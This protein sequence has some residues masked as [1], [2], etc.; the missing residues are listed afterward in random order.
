MVPGCLLL[1]LT[2]GCLRFFTG[3]EFPEIHTHLC[4]DSLA[5]G[6]LLAFIHHYHPALFVRLSR[7]RLLLAAC[8]VALVGLALAPGRRPGAWGCALIPVGLYVGYGAIL[9][10]VL[11]LPLAWFQSWLLRAL[12]GVGLYSYSIYLLHIDV[13]YQLVYSLD[14]MNW[15]GDIPGWIRWLVGMTVYV[16]LAIATG[17]LL[18]RC[19]EMP[20][21]ALRDRL[22]PRKSNHESP[23]GKG[24][25]MPASPKKELL[26]GRNYP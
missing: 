18:S 14:H 17:I 7:H 26:I 25:T 1:A 15:A 22:F 9:M 11:A 6:V 20:A 8:G 16:A 10:A 24:E 19:I 23:G 2:C 12:A 5:F 13:A 4:I 21:L 3:E